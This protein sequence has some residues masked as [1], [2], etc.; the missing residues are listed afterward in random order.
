MLTEFAIAARPDTLDGDA[1]AHPRDVGAGIPAEDLPFVFERFCRGRL[2]DSPGELSGDRG[3]GLAI[4]RQLADLN[5]WLL[6]A[7]STAG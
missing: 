5:A 3:I 4:A 2:N 1:Q 7:T 6:T